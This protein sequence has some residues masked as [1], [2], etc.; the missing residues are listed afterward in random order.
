MR[1][2]RSAALGA[3]ALAV[4]AGMN[5]HAVAGLGNIGGGLNRG[6]GL[7]G[8]TVAV[9]HAVVRIHMQRPR[10]LERLL[11]EVKVAA[12]GEDGG[13]VARHVFSSCSSEIRRK[14]T[15]PLP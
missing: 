8:R 6:E 5:Q 10:N 7:F 15:A 4:D 1:G 14:S 9:R 2:I 11:P 3:H 12:V 13:Q